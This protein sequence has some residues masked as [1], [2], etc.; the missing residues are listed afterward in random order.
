MNSL[1]HMIQRFFKMKMPCKE[2][3][4]EFL[5]Y[6]MK[7]KPWFKWLEV[8]QFKET[9]I[10]ARDN[11]LN[12]SNEN[13]MIL[14]MMNERQLESNLETPTKTTNFKPSTTNFLKEKKKSRNECLVMMKRHFKTDLKETLWRNSTCN[15][16]LKK[17]FSILHWRTN[18]LIRLKRIQTSINTRR[19][20]WSSNMIKILTTSRR[21]LKKKESDRNKTS[22]NS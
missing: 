2:E 1:I 5:K 19:I 7:L 11:N 6:W 3:S 4:K 18:S 9:C 10:M 20:K 13:L 15:N 16:S 12:N 21:I 17:T 22:P 8:Q 14:K